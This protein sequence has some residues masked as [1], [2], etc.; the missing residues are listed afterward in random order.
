[1]D[2][3]S[4]QNEM[5]QFD[6]KNRQ[7]YDE[8]TDQERKKFSSY[9]IMKYGANVDSDADFQEWYIRA[10]NERINLHFF[11]INKH[12]KLQWLLCTTVSPRLGLQ[13]HYWQASKKKE[14]DNK[15]YKF[16]AQLYPEMKVKDLELLA[17]ITSRDELKKL[18]I[19][20][21]YSDSD[22]KKVLG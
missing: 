7:F 10:T 14:G 18:A 3:L 20:M 11:D 6:L 15:I 17:D 16:L 13:R 9:L 22:I 21:G 19:E 4:I 12:E 5:R 8:L 1:M 2:K